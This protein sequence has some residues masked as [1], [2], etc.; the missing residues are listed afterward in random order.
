M[1]IRAEEISDIKYDLFP[2]NHFDM[3]NLQNK[4]KQYENLREFKEL[5]DNIN[6][7]ERDVLN[8]INNESYHLIGSLV[9]HYYYFGHH[10]AYLFPEFKLGT[11]YIADY[12]VVGK[13]SDGYHFLLIELEGVYN[14]ITIGSGDAGKAMRS[15][16]SQID[17]WSRWIEGNYS[18]FTQE[19]KKY[20]KEGR[21]LPDE[22]Y[23][24]DST[25]FNYLLIV[26]RRVD[27]KNDK[28]RRKQ[29]QLLENRL[30]VLH[31]D[32]VLDRVDDWITGDINRW[33]HEE[34]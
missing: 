11:Q 27:Y 26:G 6:C 28:I 14:Q 4:D 32:N 34:S 21:H 23:T 7:L 19:L 33:V 18:A 2:R 29:R 17:D 12:L 16:L 25:R 1:F 15:G 8:F 13:N 24:Y 9:K 10:S 31:Y 5:I 20:K 3:V 22:F 30:R